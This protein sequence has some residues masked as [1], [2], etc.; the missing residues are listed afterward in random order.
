MTRNF[1]N[2]ALCALPPFVTGAANGRSP[3]S[4]TQ[5][6]WQVDTKMTG[7]KGLKQPIAATTTNVR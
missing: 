3:P 7:K 6:P 2:L 5:A 1:A 4:V